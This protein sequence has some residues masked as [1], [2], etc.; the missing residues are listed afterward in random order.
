[1]LLVF[2]CNLDLLRSI[3]LTYWFRK[4]QPT[5]S[6]IRLVLHG[7]FPAWTG[8]MEHSPLV[9][10]RSIVPFAFSW[11]NGQI[12]GKQF[13]SLRSMQNFA[14]PPKLTTFGEA[15]RIHQHSLFIK[16][17][18]WVDVYSSQL[19]NTHTYIYN[20]IYIYTSL[21]MF[22]VYLDGGLEHVLLFHILGMSSS[23]LTMFIQ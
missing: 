17:K 2:S 21:S 3:H 14:T 18:Y 20:H 23:Q 11:C 7:H 16:L 9:V 5:N 15:T 12:P 19:T 13:Y 10:C 8:S 6:S 4:W 1:M 22:I